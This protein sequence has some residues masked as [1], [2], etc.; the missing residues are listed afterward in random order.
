MSIS[1]IAHRASQWLDLQSQYLKPLIDLSS[2]KWR[3]AK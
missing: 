1:L 3:L 2:L